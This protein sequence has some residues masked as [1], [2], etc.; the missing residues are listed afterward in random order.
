MQGANISQFQSSFN[1]DR[2]RFAL[3]NRSMFSDTRR[4][5]KSGHCFF[6]STEEETHVS[7]TDCGHCLIIKT[8]CDSVHVNELGATWCK[9]LLVR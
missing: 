9:T 5:I 2:R 3:L 8:F 6:T 1:N 7:F 4:Q